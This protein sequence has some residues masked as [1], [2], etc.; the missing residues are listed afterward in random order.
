MKDSVIEKC[1]AILKRDDVKDEL[2]KVITPLT[3]IILVEIY[4]Y[5]YLSLIFVLISFL[6]HLG[7]FILLLRNKSFVSKD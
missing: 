1:L 7:I 3:D 2:K 6:L 4:P 5:I